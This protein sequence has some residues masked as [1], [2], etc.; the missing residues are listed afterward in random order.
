V[1]AA[2]HRLDAGQQL[3]DLERLDEVVVGA[4]LEAEHALVELAA[5]REHDDRGDRAEAAQLAAH[6]EAVEVSGSIQSSRITS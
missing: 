2:Q 5:G 4:A 1:G 3:V 6:G